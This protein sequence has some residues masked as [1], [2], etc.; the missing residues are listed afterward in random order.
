MQKTFEMWARLGLATSALVLG[1]GSDT[2]SSN[3]PSGGSDTDTPSG[4]T[5]VGANMSAARS[6]GGAG[7]NAIGDAAG[8]AG[9]SGALPSNNGGGSVN[10]KDPSRGFGAVGAP[11][12]H[13][14]RGQSGHVDQR[15]DAQHPRGGEL[16]VLV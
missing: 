7:A 13:R 12:L 6:G 3:V 1:C 14:A 5:D 16:L 8:H 15:V 9:A 4:M 11:L 2:S 10:P